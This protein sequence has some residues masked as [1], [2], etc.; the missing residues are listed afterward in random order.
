MQ[1]SAS[2]QRRNP[3]VP[4][5]PVKISPSQTFSIPDTTLVREFDDECVLLNLKNESY[6][7]LDIT[8]TFIWR[9]IAAGRTI[10]EIGRMMADEFEVDPET[11]TSDLRSLVDDLLE[12]ELVQYGDD[13]SAAS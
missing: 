8:G 3:V 9:Q 6:F 13:P 5:F 1:P 2:S 11:A 4:Y 10:E 12:H 7:G